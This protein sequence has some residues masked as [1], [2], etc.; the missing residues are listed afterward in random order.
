MYPMYTSEN[1]VINGDFLIDQINETAAVTP[2][3]TGYICDMWKLDTAGL[4]SD[5]TLQVQNSVAP[6]NFLNSMKLLTASNATPTAAQYTILTH[7]VEGSQIADLAFGTNNATL[8]TITFQARSSVI[9]TY[10]VSFR[11]SAANRSYIATYATTV[12]NQWTWVS[13]TVPGD[14]TGTWLTAP[15]TIGMNISFDMGSGSNFQ[16][17]AGTWQ[18]GNFT[19]TSGAAKLVAN[20]AATLYI[21]NVQLFAGNQPIPYSPRPFRLELNLCQ[22][23]Y[24][25]TFQTGVAPAQNAGVSGAITVKNPI[26]LGDPSE[27]WQFVPKMAGTP[28][29]TTYNP[30]AANANWRNI[31]AVADV[32]VSVDPAT[33]IGQ[34][35]VL[36]ATSGAVATLGDIL[37]IHASANAG[38]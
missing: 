8:V 2:A 24:Q 12:A 10:C 17:T 25:K 16:S 18:A 22:R 21:A 5:I 4:G 31:T 35:G 15:N 3:A 13:I 7:I 20:A 37:A 30:S 9:G 26:A 36:I 34:S 11:N 6:T 1:R 38:L 32:T 33:T 27:W 19:G 28:T 23:F 29:I 14:L